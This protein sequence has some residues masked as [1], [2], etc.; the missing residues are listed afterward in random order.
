MEIVT[1]YG[2]IVGIFVS[3]IPD[4]DDPDRYPDV[5]SASIVPTI[6]RV[7]NT[8][9]LPL[10]SPSHGA[11]GVFMKTVEFPCALMPDGHLTGDI[12]SPGV[13][14]PDAVPGMWL[15]IGLYKISLLG[16]APDIE[17]L[18]EERHTQESPLDLY[19][20]AK[21]VSD[22]SA[23]LQVVEIPSGGGSNQVLAWTPQ[24]LSWYDA[25]A[26]SLSLGSVT[27]TGE[28]T[29]PSV[30][31]SGTPP[32]QTIDFTF[33]APKQG[34]PGNPTQYDL[35]G[36]GMPNGVVTGNPGDTY[37]DTAGTNG[38]WKW[39][40]K[41]GTGNTGW[42]VIQGDTGWRDISAFLDPNWVVG[43]N[44]PTNRI[45][46]TESLVCIELRIQPA[47]SIQGTSQATQYTVIP[48]LPTGFHPGSYSL[49]A[50]AMSS[51]SAGTHV[52]HNLSSS[53]K[54]SVSPAYGLSTSLTWQ[55]SSYIM[56]QMMF[57]T[58]RPWPDTLPGTAI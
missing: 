9:N 40:K 37:T 8:E 7:V 49:I 2:Y 44:A 29:A 11:S 21:F 46:R 10:V 28:D 48:V 42:E 32:L 20:Y 43:A 22:P 4:S 13:A 30:T 17:F 34:A 19:Q 58:N 55:T 38:A 24:G 6:T 51:S 27:Q 33:P 3:R 1:K 26:N 31:I 56:G 53:S 39:M 47:A 41:S 52:F 12:A 14:S 16:H 25:P 23:P 45:R 18:V 36:T 57:I 54:V 35:R 5:I 15:P 50:P